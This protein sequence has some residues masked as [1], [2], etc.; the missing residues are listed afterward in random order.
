MSRNTKIKKFRSCLLRSGLVDVTDCSTNA[1]TIKLHCLH[2]V[3]KISNFLLP[4]CIKVS[5]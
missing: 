2:P 4:V 5:E 3:L 1:F